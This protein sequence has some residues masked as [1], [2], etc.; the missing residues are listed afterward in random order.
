MMGTSRWLLPVV[1]DSVSSQ[2]D[3]EGNPRTLEGS[4][5]TQKRGTLNNLPMPCEMPGKG[6]AGPGQLDNAL[7]FSRR[8]SC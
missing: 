5:G 2:C 3:S 6:L 4:V 1:C 7:L 8:E